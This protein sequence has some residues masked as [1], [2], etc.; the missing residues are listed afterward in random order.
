MRRQVVSPRSHPLGISICL[1]PRANIF[2]KMGIT[3][4]LFI[5]KIPDVS[6]SYPTDFRFLSFATARARNFMIVCVFPR[7]INFPPSLRQ[8]SYCCTLEFPRRV[9]KMLRSSVCDSICAASLQASFEMH[10]VPHISYIRAKR[11]LVYVFIVLGLC[12]CRSVF[13]RLC[14]L[15]P[16]SRVEWQFSFA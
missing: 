8:S 3:H 7:P 4:L 10:L 12:A 13:S 5:L 11:C 9:R 14:L 1:A 15:L 6:S 2:L 16:C